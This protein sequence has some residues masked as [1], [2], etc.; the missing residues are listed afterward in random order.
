M[1]LHLQRLGRHG[2]VRAR[3]LRHLAL[4]HFCAP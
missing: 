3:L 2:Q 4:R 1:G